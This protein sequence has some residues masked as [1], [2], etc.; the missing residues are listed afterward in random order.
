MKLVHIPAYNAPAAFP[1]DMPDHEI[2]G[3]IAEHLGLLREDRIRGSADLPL[4]RD[5]REKAA[6]MGRALAV[7]GGFDRIAASPK[8]RTVETARLMSP[9]AFVKLDPDLE[10]MNYG[11]FEGQKSKDAIPHINHFIAHRPHEPLPGISKFS[12]KP[13]ESFH[14]YKARLLPAIHKIMKLAGKH[15]DEKIALMLNRRSIKTLQSWMKSGQKPDL[16]TDPKMD[17][18]FSAGDVPNGSIW[19]MDGG[20]MTEVK[21]PGNMGPGLYVMRHQATHWNS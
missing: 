6:E 17:T 21:D 20:G 12:G 5:G 4:T 15:P 1:E 11:H 8:K 10:D 9:H 2:A 14:A 3:H 16:S 18:E 7:H 13:G 19:K